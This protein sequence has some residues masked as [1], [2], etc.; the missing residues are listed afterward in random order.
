MVLSRLRHYL[1]SIFG[2]SPREL[3]ALYPR[4][5]WNQLESVLRYTIRNK[6][7]FV[8]ALV[9][10]SF[11]P[12]AHFNGLASNERLEFLGDAVLELVSTTF[13]YKKYPKSD[14]GD[15]TAFRSA[16]VNAVNLAEVAGKLGMEDYLLLSHGEQKD[17]GK[18][19]MY[20]LANTIEA[21]IGALYLDGGYDAAEKFIAD[22]VLCLI[23]AIVANRSWIDAKSFFQEKAQDVDGVT[24]VYKVL[25]ESGPDHDKSFS[26]GVYIRD[27]KIGEGEGKSKQEAEQDAARDA[28][29]VKGW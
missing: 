24:P 8:S 2:S 17:K 13:L 10:R 20:I 6:D 4:V 22:H 11:I 14:E 1:S 25:K 12:V 7:Y 9:H 19:R 15:L 16:L 27:K 29:K 21:F 26:I 5:D 3:H 28:L 18:A 23:D